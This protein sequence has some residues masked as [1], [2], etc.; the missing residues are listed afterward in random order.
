MVSVG[1]VAPDFELE[2]STGGKLRLSASRGHPV[3]LYFFPKADT[4]GCTIESKAFRDMNPDLVAKGVQVLGISVDKLD[5]QEHFATKCSLPFP[6]LA[7][8]TK[9]VAK[10]Y[11][12]LGLLGMARR[13]TFF[14]D[15][16]GKVA[17][18]V[19]ASGPNP[20]VERAR[21]RFLGAA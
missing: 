9:A 11:G 13:V 15:G 17:D 5:A 10:S 12:V 21:Q 20:H 8:S 1:D 3:V 4:P 18:I 16:D 6:L 14:I 19:E 7:D 2:S